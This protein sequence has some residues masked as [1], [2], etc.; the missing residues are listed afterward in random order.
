M[1]L[2]RQLQRLW[3][4]DFHPLLLPLIPL[5]WL[6]RCIVG[7]RRVAFRWRLLRSYRVSKPVIVVGNV[8]VGG[9][10]KTP[11]TIWL[12]NLLAEQGLRVGIILRGYG[13]TG[14][15]WPKR[16][17]AQTP[18]EEVGDEACLLA[19][20]TS[21]I[22]V[23]G[24]DRVADARHAIEL[25]AQVVISDDGLQHYRL[26]RDVEI[27]VL[28]AV[29]QLGNG[30]LLPAGPLREPRSRMANVDLQV[31]T[32]RSARTLEPYVVNSV[33][34]I[35]A[36]QRLHSAVNLVT[37]EQRALTS[38]QGR[39]IHAIAAIG[40]PEGFFQALRQHGLE[41]REHA[42]PDHAKLTAEEISFSDDR[43]VLMTEKDAVKCSAFVDDRHWAVPLDIELSHAERTAV[44]DLMLSV[45]EPP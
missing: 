15:G 40:H 30:R 36:T 43:A 26:Q 5:S 41:V 44:H 22:V 8:T 20:R 28:D 6:F 13:G 23:A 3:Y 16:V 19:R 31:I 45:L 38:F 33:P 4:G 7:L 21:A 11:F 17:T 32:Q 27:V 2:D 34:V 9:T 37:E 35:A 12:A 1:S 18:W 42:Y 14:T 25:G 29:R 24:P 39:A 10:G